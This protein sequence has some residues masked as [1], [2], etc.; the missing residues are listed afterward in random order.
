LLHLPRIIVGLK[1]AERCWFAVDASAC[2]VRASLSFFFLYIKSTSR[3]IWCYAIVYTMGQTKL[4][5]GICTTWHDRYCSLPLIW[6]IWILAHQ[7]T[8]LTIIVQ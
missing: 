8:P 2:I 3:M 6:V 1:F 4:Y 7:T 5:G